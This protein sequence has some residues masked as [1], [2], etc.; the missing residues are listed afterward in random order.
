M[1]TIVKKLS[2]SNKGVLT[3]H[4]PK[5]LTDLLDITRETHCAVI[6]TNE[7]GEMILT[8]GDRRLYWDKT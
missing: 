6:S 5:T 8:I 3:V 4:L 2:C 7:D 1:G